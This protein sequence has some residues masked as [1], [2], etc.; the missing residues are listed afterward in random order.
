M[1]ANTF[2]VY[3][4]MLGILCAV[5]GIIFSSPLAIISGLFGVLFSTQYVIRVVAVKADL[6]KSFG[7]NWLETI[8]QEKRQRLYQK[9]M[10]FW[11]SRLPPARCELDHPFW[12][13]PGTT[14]VL[15]CD[16]WQPPL[17]VPSSGLAVIY[18]HT[19]EWH[20]ADKN[21][22]TEPLFR[23]LVG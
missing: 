5:L 9:Q 4:A 21:F 16:L 22:G 11:P 6:E 12:T 20:F 13:I 17:D 7:P 15:L 2:A 23:Q 14:R 3:L 8:P 10:I 19:G 1:I 18:L